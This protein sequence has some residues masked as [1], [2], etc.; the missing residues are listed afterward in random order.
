VMPAD[1]AERGLETLRG[2]GCAAW[3][4]GEVVEGGGIG[5]A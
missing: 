2:V 3:R 1:E 4:I 5:F